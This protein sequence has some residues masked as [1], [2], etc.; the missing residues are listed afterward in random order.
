[1]T[2]TI[3]TVERDEWGDVTYAEGMD[4]EGR[5]FTLEHEGTHAELRDVLRARGFSDDEILA[6]FSASDQVRLGH[7]LSFGVQPHSWTDHLPT[8][9][10][11]LIPRRT[12]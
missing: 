10:A 4:H 2:A 11:R 8:F 9:I 7:R 1:M 5:A 6:S 3:R 12:R